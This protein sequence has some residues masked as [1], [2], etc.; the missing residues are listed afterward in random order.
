MIGT[1]GSGTWNI[2][3]SV[4][5][6][7]SNLTGV[8]NTI[9]VSVGKRVEGTWYECLVKTS[10]ESISAIITAEGCQSIIIFKRRSVMKRS[11]KR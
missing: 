8:G 2:S 7:R 4:E 10:S 3:S 5:M 6:L 9:A 1:G 11:G